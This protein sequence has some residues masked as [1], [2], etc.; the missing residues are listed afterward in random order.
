MEPVN[1]FATYQVG[2]KAPSYPP[3]NNIIL[4]SGTA[5]HIINDRSRFVDEFQL[6]NDF[7]Y[8]GT[9]LDPIKNFKTAK[10]TIQTLDETKRIQL[11]NTVYIL[12]FYTSQVCL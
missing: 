2:A 11:K 10:I 9:G 7:I 12:N 8:A 1:I 5:I 6:N 4:D 3:H